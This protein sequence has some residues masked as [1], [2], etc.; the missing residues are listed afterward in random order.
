MRGQS[1]SVSPHVSSPRSS[2]ITLG[3]I[4]DASRASGAAGPAGRGAGA[5]RRVGRRA[6]RSLGGGA[7]GGGPRRERASA[8]R[9][10]RDD[11]GQTAGKKGPRQRGHQP[12]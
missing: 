9:G 6:G 11:P 1:T 10:N 4:E 2:A 12:D 3:A 8:A 5:A 7:G